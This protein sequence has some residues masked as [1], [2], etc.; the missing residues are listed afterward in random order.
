[1][2]KSFV[3]ERSRLVLICE[4]CDEPGCFGV[5]CTKDKIGRWYCPEHARERGLPKK[6]TT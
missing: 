3:D 2:T 4:D 6:R 5:G 1:M